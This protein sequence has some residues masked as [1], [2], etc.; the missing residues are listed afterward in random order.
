MSSKERSIW[1]VRAG[2]GGAFG[3]EFRQHGIV[4]IGWTDIGD[5]SGLATRDQFL[6][7]VDAVYPQHKRGRKVNS[8]S[9]LYRFVHKITP[10]DVVMTPIRDTRE[11]HMGQVLGDYS[12]RPDLIERLPNTREVKWERT[13]SRDQLSTAARNA[14]GSTL[15]VFR[16]NE[17][18]EELLAL[19][20]GRES[21]IDDLDEDDAAGLELYEE[22]KGKADELISDRISHMDPYDFQ[23][24][25]AALLRAMGFYTQVSPP[26][27]DRGVDIVAHP[28]SL[29]FQTPRI[30][31][32]VKQR[33]GTAGGQDL[34]NF[35]S[36]LREGERGLFVST[37]GF[38]KDAQY[39]AERAP[40]GISVTL[41]D[42]DR[43][44]DLLG[45]YYDRLDP[46]AK[47]L[48]PLKT[49]LIPVEGD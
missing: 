46:L 7:R 11:I 37:G 33:S 19:Y 35:M 38:S 10:G 27:P 36:T 44:V 5:L 8:A 47:A 26:G 17:Y 1:V 41:V 18:R 31:A 15:T 23:D 45:E 48:L 32:Q 40:R 21:R 2:H 49:I 13:I 9:Q 22:I 24:L 4:A 28:D 14:A 39:E 25:V 30:K 34:R 3:D 29:G 43:F 20:E 6:E 16:L 42:R 12:Y